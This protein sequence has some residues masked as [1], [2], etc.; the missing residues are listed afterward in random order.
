MGLSEALLA[1]LALVLILEGLMPFLSPGR[2]RKL[3]ERVLQLSDE[4]LR[5]F[6]FVSIALGLTLLWVFGPG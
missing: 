5:V 2:W 4:E 3:F 6:G 1:S